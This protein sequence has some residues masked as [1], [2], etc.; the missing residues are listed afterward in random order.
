MLGEIC[1][2][3]GIAQPV[4]IQVV[5]FLLKSAQSTKCKT[6]RVLLNSL[7]F[8]KLKLFYEITKIIFEQPQYSGSW[9]LWIR[10]DHFY[11]IVYQPWPLS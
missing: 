10:E 5:E 8:K 4:I 3:T 7:T 2:A 11:Y 6:E 1:P 9:S